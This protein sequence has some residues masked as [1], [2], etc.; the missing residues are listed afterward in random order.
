MNKH[1]RNLNELRRHLGRDK[2]G[3]ELLD[4]ISR[5][6]TEQRKT[7]AALE[8]AVTA[9]TSQAQRARKG[10]QD[11]QT[12]TAQVEKELQEERQRAGALRSEAARATARL[13]SLES[14][15]GDETEDEDTAGSVPGAIDPTLRHVE[16][17]SKRVRAYFKRAPTPCKGR[18]NLGKYSGSIR[19]EDVIKEYS[20]DEFMHLG[21]LVAMMALHNWPVSVWADCKVMHMNGWK[22]KNSARFIRWVRDWIKADHVTEQFTGPLKGETIRNA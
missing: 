1:K 19:L 10:E 11:A 8:G 20:G 17:L 6:L 14:C 16:R 5:D 7:I 15:V 3:L 9:A 13:R 12:E 2:R 22:E 21:M 4:A 18:A